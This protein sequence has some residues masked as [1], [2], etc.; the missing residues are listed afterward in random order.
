MNITT[1]TSSWSSEKLTVFILFLLVVDGLAI[2]GN[3]LVIVVV[4]WTK[5]L[6]R[7]EANFFVL[8]L[9]VADLLVAL[10]IVP[11]TIASLV[12]P[13][14][15][16]YHHYKTF[17][18]FGNFFF[19]ICSIMNLTL[20][21]LDRYFAIT[22][23]YR[24]LDFMT[25]KRACSLCILVWVYSLG[26]SLPP[27]FGISSYACFIPNFETCREDV[28]RSSDTLVFAFLVLG[29][30]YV[31]SLTSMSFCYWKI[32]KVARSHSRQIAAQNSIKISNPRKKQI[33]DPSTKTMQKIAIEPPKVEE[34][35]SQS[36]QSHQNSTHGKIDGNDTTGVRYVKKTLIDIA[37]APWINGSDFEDSL[38]SCPNRSNQR[39]DKDST[40]HSTKNEMRVARSFLIIIGL[41]V[42]CW[43]PFCLILA[44]EIVLRRKLSEE[45]S[46]ICLWIGYINSCVNPFIYTWKYRQFRSAL[47]GL[48]RKTCI[49]KR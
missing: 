48:W 15:F 42:L 25:H 33:L 18:G 7:M 8:S 39:T 36:I 26:F 40:F 10:T 38:R 49:C 28:W 6:R 11:I 30:T 37:I 21:S 32:F 24:Y 13:R 14:Y 17:L 47:I 4:L 41:Y 27:V 34:I 23:P 12:N 9:S 22:S 20:L 46:L 3:V 31:L 19:C 5:S 45:A 16:P 2:L 44:S 43:T 1:L 35:N 29:F